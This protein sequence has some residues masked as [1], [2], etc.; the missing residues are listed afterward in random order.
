[1]GIGKG[2]HGEE[3]LKVW[4]RKKGTQ[5]LEKAEK[6]PGRV[7]IVLRASL[8]VGKERLSNSPEGTRDA[9]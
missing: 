3:L 7:W 8:V 6:N 2:T 9:K 4:G 5:G 1:M